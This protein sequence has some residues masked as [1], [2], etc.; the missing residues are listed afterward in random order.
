MER[1]RLLALLLELCVQPS[2][3]MRLFVRLCLVVLLAPPKQSPSLHRHHRLFRASLADL[4]LSLLAL[5]TGE[6]E[7][8]RHQKQ[9]LRWLPCC[10][11]DW[12]HRV[13]PSRPRAPQDHVQPWRAE[14]AP[15]AHGYERQ[16]SYQCAVTRNSYI[17]A[18]RGDAI[19]AIGVAGAF[20]VLE[21]IFRCKAGP[22]VACGHGCMPMAA[23]G[24]CCMLG[25]GSFCG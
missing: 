17:V 12:Q 8:W 19:R 18:G 6:Q 20:R 5:Q 25:L 14:A 10:S 9:Q 2:L 15:C 21:A 1:P 7:R 13:T 4:K 16:A 3:A 23:T 22:S 11:Y 24:S